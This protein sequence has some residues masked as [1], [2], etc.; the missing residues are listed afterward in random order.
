MPVTL[1]DDQV[2]ELRQ[3]LGQA[4]TNRQIAEAARGVWDDPDLGEAAK[5]L[6]KQKYPDTSI[7]DY[8]LEQ[9]LRGEIQK[10]RDERA[11]ADKAARDREADARVASERKAVQDRYG[12]TDDA[13]TRLERLM[14]ERNIGDYEVAAEYMFSREPR[15]SDGRDDSYDGQ[16]W[17]HDQ[18]D[19]FKEIAADPEEWGRKEILKTLREGERQRPG[20]RW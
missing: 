10:D 3:R 5:R 8:D 6:W 7:P 19:L 14:V 18:Q 16:Y 13:M 17:R 20:T 4:E 1:N 12:A 9:R 15:A 11:A 2:A